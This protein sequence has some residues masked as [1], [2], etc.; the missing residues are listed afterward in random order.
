MTD[1]VFL[2]I[3][4]ARL[5]SLI[6]AAKERVVFAA[7]GVD[8]T[9]SEA[10]VAAAERLQGPSA[11]TVV[12]DVDP[13]VC[14]LGY[15][16]IGG[17]EKLRDKGVQVRQATG[18]RIGL[19]LRD[20]R[21]WLFAPTP[22]LV[23]HEGHRDETPNAVAVEPAQ[24]ERLLDAICPTSQSPPVSS[25]ELAGDGDA[26]GDNLLRTEIGVTVVSQE[27]VQE[28]QES[29]RENPPLKF[30]LARKVRVFNS[31][32]EFAEF[33][34]EG[35]SIDRRKVDLPE[36][37]TRLVKDETI[38]N[39]LRTQFSLLGDTSKIA[40]RSKEIN[41]KVADIRETYLKNIGPRY[42]RVILRARKAAF[43]DEVERLRRDIEK[44]EREIRDQLMTEL[45]SSRGKLVKEL[46]PNIRKSPPR[47]LQG[48]IQGDKPTKE[49]AEAYLALEL[50]RVFPTAADLVE[51]MRLD[52]Q[53]K[54]VTYETL[55][56][57]DFQNA[58]R[59]A[60]PLVDWKKPFHEFD[61]SEGEPQDHA[62]PGSLFGGS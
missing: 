13:E 28:T 26:A 62:T 30:D 59:K 34:F 49:E 2:A 48:Q 11:V 33:S 54:G 16:T 17:I 39:R 23:E 36:R 25:H 47:E 43:L 10:L 42:G 51:D 7:P 19:L 31:F 35:G 52:V 45:G 38:Q 3:H 14:R 58:V 55:Q 32:V 60:L 57:E 21:G 44:Y 1:R 6:D 22:L 53:F 8:E 41:R 61:A 4:P 29:L 40:K 24:A 15:G 46:V 37:I 20:D 5:K 9:I 27:Q 56:S 18:L 12:L 50:D